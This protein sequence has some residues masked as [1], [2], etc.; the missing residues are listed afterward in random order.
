MSGRHRKPAAPSAAGRAAIVATTGAFA[1]V[2]VVLGTVGAGTAS[3]AELAPE[4]VAP[5][6]SI[7]WDP[8]I[9]C[10]SGGN[11]RATNS[12]STASGLFQFVN[13][14]WKAYGGGQ[15]AARAKD[16]TP[17]EQLAVANTAFEKSGLTPWAASK[18][19]WKGQ[20]DTSSTART[21]SI[22]TTLP[23]KSTTIRSVADKKA[24]PAAGGGSYTVVAGD[25]LSGIAAK[26]GM[27]W[28]SVWSANKGSVPKPGMLH[29]G[30]Q[31]K[32]PTAGDINA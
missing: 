31:L 32:L 30:E 4:S 5:A 22:T 24:A 28:Q 23:S 6:P 29:P 17:A 3:A 11:P 14:S 9:K 20:V 12:S 21:T 27:S 2:P 13:G 25:T 8:I 10:E 16:A 19:C 26:H 15:Y 18:H 1:A 7:N